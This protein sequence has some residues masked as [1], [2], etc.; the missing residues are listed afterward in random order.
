MVRIMRI[1]SL[2]IFFWC[3][4][5]QAQTVIPREKYLEFARASA[6]WTWNHLDSLVQ[7]WQDRFDPE[8]IWGYRPP[9]RLLETAAI[10][11]T[12]VEIEG[13]QQ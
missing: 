4:V 3:I 7:D 13:N 6:D 2:L 10:Y 1:L 12:L 8:N 9:P 11:A 5:V